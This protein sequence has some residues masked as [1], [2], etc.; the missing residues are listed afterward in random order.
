[1]IDLRDRTSLIVLWRRMVTTTRAKK[2]KFWGLGI[3]TTAAS[4]PDD[5]C[6]TLTLISA[7][8]WLMRSAEIGGSGA[9]IAEI[10]REFMEEAGGQ[11][12]Q[13]QLQTPKWLCALRKA[14]QS[15]GGPAPCSGPTYMPMPAGGVAGGAGTVPG[16]IWGPEQGFEPTPD[17]VK[18]TK[19][20]FLN[21]NFCKNCRRN[22][23]H[24]SPLCDQPQRPDLPCLFCMGCHRESDCPGPSD[25]SRPAFEVKHKY[26]FQRVHSAVPRHLQTGGGASAGGAAVPAAVA[27]PAGVKPG[28]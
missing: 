14:G 3:Q 13:I 15:P 28:G 7:F 12:S 27:D 2:A 17:Q 16:L 5:L 11:A 26:F 8:L 20:A 25:R 21:P 1:M 23:G 9:S 18:E 4:A 24:P 10:W 6:T 19:V 22:A